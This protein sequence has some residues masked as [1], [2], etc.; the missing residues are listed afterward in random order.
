M[1]QDELELARS[2][3]ETLQCMAGNGYEIL[4][5]GTVIDNILALIATIIWIAI[6]PY[7]IVRTYKK[8]NIGEKEDDQ[9]VAWVITMGVFAFL[10][11]AMIY[12]TKTYIMGIS[13]PEYVV[14]N[15]VIT[16]A[17]AGGT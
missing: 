15:K 3:M 14:I 2:A 7:V 11:F 1:N 8:F 12:M 9:V 17:V 6:V 16:A 5:R 10:V 4:V 13:M